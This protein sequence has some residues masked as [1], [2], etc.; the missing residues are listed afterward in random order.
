MSASH[1]RLGA[2]S[3]GKYRGGANALESRGPGWPRSWRAPRRQLSRRAHPQLGHA[4]AR[5][6][7]RSLLRDAMM[8]GGSTPPPQRDPRTVLSQPYVIP[9][10]IRRVSSQQHVPGVGAPPEAEDRKNADPA[11]GTGLDPPVPSSPKKPPRVTH[12]NSA[13]PAAAAQA[14]NVWTLS[15]FSSIFGRTADRIQLPALGSLFVTAPKP[16]IPSVTRQPC[17][18]VLHLAPTHWVQYTASKDRGGGAAPSQGVR[19]N[20]GN[21]QEEECA[22]CVVQ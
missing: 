4:H 2:F 20:G 8:D 13:N 1:H 18:S 10:P 14:S 22:S 15:S 19:G 5:R 6:R 12:G 11:A 17:V 3:T 9:T 16:T 21:I 7:P